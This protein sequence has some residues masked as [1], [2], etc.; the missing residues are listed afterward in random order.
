MDGYKKFIL[1]GCLV[2]LGGYFLPWVTPFGQALTGYAAL[3]LGLEAID[4][5]QSI[6]QYDYSVLA[7][8]I[9]VILPATA[10]ALSLVYCLLKPTR[11]NGSLASFLF[12]LPVLT[13]VA[14]Y[15][16]LGAAQYGLAPG[17][18]ITRP[19]VSLV[20]DSALDL[21]Q[22]AGLWMLHLGALMML[23]GRSSR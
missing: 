17:E 1:V 18:A 23:L 19:F 5:M 9:S 16:Y 2:L 6:G 13:L 20:R 21:A 8:S 11:G 12:T 22:T 10:A 4:T 15:A 7:I 14:V 3:R